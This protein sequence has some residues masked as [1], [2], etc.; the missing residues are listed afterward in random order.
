M[1]VSRWHLVALVAS[2][3]LQLVLFVLVLILAA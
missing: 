3:A 2:L 1:T